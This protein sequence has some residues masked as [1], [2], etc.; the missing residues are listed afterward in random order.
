MKRKKRGKRKH[1]M[2]KSNSET[3][4]AKRRFKERYGIEFNKEMRKEMIR[5]IQ[6]SQSH[7]VE[8]QSR[9]VTVRDV[10]YGGEVYRVVYDSIRQ[11]IITVLPKE[12][13]VSQQAEEA[14]SNPV[15]V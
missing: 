10:I 8:V 6:M 15:N 4:H 2:T 11:N 14:G 12:A 5:L 9:R 3:F 1:K 7:L 13:Q